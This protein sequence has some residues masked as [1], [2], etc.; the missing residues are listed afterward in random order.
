[1]SHV[2]DLAGALLNLQPDGIISSLGNCLFQ[3]ELE[4]RALVFESRNCKTERT[5]TAD[6][7]DIAIAPCA[8]GVFGGRGEDGARRT[9]S[10]SPFLAFV[11]EKLDGKRPRRSIG[12][13]LIERRHEALIL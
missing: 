4:I 13:T 11:P 2:L 5:G 6:G 9:D 3:F 1:M 8:R 7:I 12:G 10:Q